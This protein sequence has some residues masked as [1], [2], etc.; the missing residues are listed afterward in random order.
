MNRLRCPIR[1]CDLGD[2]HSRVLGSPSVVK[3]HLEDDLHESSFHLADMA[4]C[5]EVGIYSCT[6][7]DCPTAPKRFF[8]SKA[9]LDRHNSEHHPTFN[10]TPAATSPPITFPFAPAAEPNGTPASFRP[11]VSTSS[12]AAICNATILPYIGSGSI[13]SKWAEGLAFIPSV[14]SHDPPSFRSTF[15][16]KLNRKNGRRF[17]R[18][19]AAIISAIVQATDAL[20]HDGSASPSGETPAQVWWLLIH[21]EM[22]L[23]APA[24]KRQRGGA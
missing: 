10:T 15:K 9:Q 13:R 16:R 1:G 21:L 4:V 6:L 19:H 24:T 12:L 5:Q 22:L 7:S 2:G 23:L 11:D 18:L 20:G 3:R 14:Y 17:T 8:T